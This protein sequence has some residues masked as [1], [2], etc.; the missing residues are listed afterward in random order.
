[1]SKKKKN[2]Q[3]N[4]KKAS[5]LNKQ[6]SPSSTSSV[7]NNGKSNS[8]VE[9]KDEVPSTNGDKKTVLPEPE[10]FKKITADHVGGAPSK[11]KDPVKKAVYADSN[12]DML[13][14][15]RKER[16]KAK[17]ELYH[18]KT[19]GMTKKE[20]FNYLFLYY[21]WAVIIPVVCIVFVCYLA[22]TIYLNKRPVALGYAILNAPNEQYMHLEEFE[23]EYRAYY[24]IPD[25]NQFYRSTSM[26][27]DY[28]YY[29]DHKDY[30]E[31]GNGTD[32]N[33]LL[34]ECELG[35]YD[36]IITNKVGARYCCVAKIAK[37]L[38][39][40]LSEKT[41]SALEPYM[42]ELKGPTNSNAYY[43]ID[44]SETDFAKN[45]IPTF[46]QHDAFILLPDTTDRNYT[47]SIRFL[48]YVFGLD[49]SE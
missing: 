41:Y 48:E 3:S 36:V 29:L 31:T 46:S 33:T 37:P 49:L 43:A 15:S 21:K 35:R 14:M 13:E 27:I 44:I 22:H 25:G 7:I 23:D 45:I 28:D 2:K 6:Q 39:S 42:V 40:A 34:S 12:L 4:K 30:I 24:D 19:A 20:R 17:R 11:P 10:K 16:R 18:Q 26:S 8:H 32:Y 5:T 38:K 1:M 47:N 9:R